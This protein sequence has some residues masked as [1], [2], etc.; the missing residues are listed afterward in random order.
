MGAP[1]HQRQRARQFEVCLG[2]HHLAA[3][4]IDQVSLAAP[5]GQGD[6]PGPRVRQGVLEG[7]GAAP[8]PAAAL[9][10]VVTLAAIVLARVDP[11]DLG[12]DVVV[13]ALVDPGRTL[14]PLRHGLGDV[15]GNFLQGLLRALDRA[16]QHAVEGLRERVAALAAA[17]RTFDP[18]QRIGSRRVQLAAVPGDLPRTVLEL[19]VI[20]TGLLAGTAAVPAAAAGRGQVHTALAAVP[21]VTTTAAG[22]GR[23]AERAIR[24]VQ[25]HVLDHR[26]QL[27]VDWLGQL[28]YHLV[29][30]P[31]DRLVDDPLDHLPHRLDLGSTEDGGQTAGHP[32]KAD[33]QAHRACHDGEFGLGLVLHPLDDL[34]E[35]VAGVREQ[36]GQLRS[37]SR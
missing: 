23:H 4:D 27:R 12:A 28:R 29:Y 22:R 7:V 10:A 32:G 8:A 13:L 16:V 19:D 11:V 33:G 20:D 9:A 2:Q 24:E 31:L 30:D 17:E 37:F 1:E 5:A 21:T 15:L 25:D 26:F 36:P 3:G 14:D 34:G 35:G 6:G 18:A